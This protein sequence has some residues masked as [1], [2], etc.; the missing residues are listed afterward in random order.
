MPVT[1]KD[2]RDLAELLH[3]DPSTKRLS[4]KVDQ[5]TKVAGELATSRH[6]KGYQSIYWKK[7]H[8]LAHRV[9]FLKEHGYLVDRVEH[10]PGTRSRYPGVYYV[11]RGVR[12]WMAMITLKGKRR[13]LGCFATQELA[14]C[15][16][17]DAKEKFHWY[18]SRQRPPRPTL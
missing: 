12:K 7:M 10:E 1:E 6:S 3:Y 2:Y 14:Y 15:A 11:K 5:G 9:I 17:C 8:F 18:E 13:Y 16:Y 4:W